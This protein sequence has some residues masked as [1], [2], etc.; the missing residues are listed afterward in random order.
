MP[1]RYL[2]AVTCPSCGTRFQ[3]PIEQVVDVRVDPAAKNR[4]LSGTV[5]VAACPACGAGGPLNIP[6]IYH[7]PENEVALLYLP[8]ESG[9]N[10][11]ERQRAAGRLTRQ[12]MDSMAPEERKGYLLRPETFIGMESL[13]KRVL[14][15]E[16]VPEDDMAHS[17]P[18][19]EFL[20]T[21]LQASSDEWAGLLQEQADLV[22]EGLFAFLEYVVQ[23]SGMTGQ[24]VADAE[25]L[26][27]LH[28]YLVQETEIG[29][30]L[31]K[32]SEVVRGF[33]DN[34]TRE[35]LLDALVAAPDDETL[36]V[37]VQAGASMMDYAFFQYFVQ[38]IDSTDAPGDK[39]TLQALRRTVLDLRDE[40]IAQNEDAVRE[41]SMLLGKLLATEDPQRMAQS[42]M[43]ELDELFFVVMG[44]Q[45]REAQQHNRTAEVEALQR[46]AGA[47]NRVIEGNMPPEIALIRRLMAAPSDDRLAQALEASREMLTPRLLQFLEALESQMREQ[48]QDEAAERLVKIARMARE[49]VPV[50]EPPAAA[51]SAPLSE[52]P[53][54]TQ[55]ERTPSGLIIAKR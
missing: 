6:F 23:L 15:L 27:A 29:R 35:T 7:D 28:E 16:G 4:V 45:L 41:R 55:E 12:L 44:S 32:R 49:Y 18:Q 21:L 39:A 31:A 48:G 50:A 43:S 5:N 54:A 42:H 11:V 47:V 9:P 8:V 2:A 40:L 51:P 10:E 33:A 37:L 34:P 36:R 20:G 1:P 24:Q 13:I 17:Q 30:S 53:S 14:A 46:V 22:D 3:T 38:R 19:R 26:Q 52:E 25:K